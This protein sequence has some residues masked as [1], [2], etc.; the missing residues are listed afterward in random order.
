MSQSVFKIT[1]SGDTRRWTPQR[2]LS[3]GDFCA[4]AKALF[5]DLNISHFKYTDADGDLV[6]VACDEDLV[7]LFQ[8]G[9]TVVRIE[10]LSPSPPDVG[11]EV[12][13]SGSDTESQKWSA[14]QF[15]KYLTDL[16]AHLS[17]HDSFPE[18]TEPFRKLV[19]LLRKPCGG[20]VDVDHLGKVVELLEQATRDSPGV[21]E[22]LAVVANRPGGRGP[23]C[24][25]AVTLAQAAI[26]SDLT[27]LS[28]LVASS[29]PVVHRGVVCDGCGMRPIVGKRFKS[30]KRCNF[31]LC[32]ECQSKPEWAGE[33]FVVVEEPCQWRRDGPCGFGKRG[34]MGA[35]FGGGRGRCCRRRFCDGEGPGN[36]KPKVRMVE[37]VTLPD[38]AK[39]L[40]GQTV[41]KT[42]RLRNSGCLPW[43]P[44]GCGLVLLWVGGDGL[45]AP[46]ATPQCV[47]SKA[48]EEDEEVEVSVTLKV[49]EKPGRYTA[50]FRMAQNGVPEPM[51]FG[52]R[53]WAQL[54]VVKDP[55]DE[56]SA[57]AQGFAGLRVLPDSGAA[58]AAGGEWV[59]VANKAQIG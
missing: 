7:E 20:K 48:P 14:K 54:M 5:G 30:A 36:C 13:N 46:P 53:I 28:S 18:C 2:A 52:P 55:S 49:P 37:D 22:A 21:R 35:G 6:T 44:T 12:L 45:G 3:Y 9:L 50:Y 41:V 51:R 59:D 57:I 1:F 32:E 19:R 26:N 43:D 24:R 39:V 29:Q 58:A 11:H 56:D 16:R 31:D 27:S 38:G 40:P 4:K 15:E 47:S 33:Q 8:Q 42:W 23:G 10:V 34:R 25:P 17:S